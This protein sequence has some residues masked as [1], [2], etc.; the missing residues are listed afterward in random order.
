MKTRRVIIKPSKYDAD[1]FV[2][3]FR[4]G[5]MPNGTISHLASMTPDHVDGTACKVHTVDEYVRTEL[6]YLDLLGTSYDGR[7]LVALVGVQSHQFHRALDLAALAV[8]RGAQAII[9][10]PHPMTCDTAMLQN[11][12]ASFA[13]AEAELLWPAILSDTAAGELRP[14]YGLDRK[15]MSRLDPPILRPLPEQELRRYAVPMMGVYPARGCPY[16]CNFCSV[17]KIAGRR[18]RGQPI[19]TTTASLRAAKQAGVRYIMFTSDNFN[20]YPEAH[21]LLDIMIAE[22]IHLPFFAQCDALLHRQEDLVEKMARAG[23][24]QIFVGAESFDRYALK[25]TRKFH[26]NPEAYARIVAMCRARGITSH[27]SNIIGFP[28]DTAESVRGH[29][30]ALR[31]LDPDLASFYILTPIPGSD[32]YDDFRR[33]GIISE[34]NL[35][36]FD[37]TC[38]T[39]RHPHFSGKELL[40]LLF[41]SY[42]TFYSTRGTLSRLA[43]LMNGP[44]DYR[45]SAALVAVAGFSAMS[46]WAA[47]VGRHPMAG[48]IARIRRD[49]ARDYADLRRSVFGIDRAPLPDS[50]ALPD[51]DA[52]IGRGEEMPAV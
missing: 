26:N 34:N 14:V 23:S 19:E 27:F 12:G 3:R 42:G 5:F 45:R 9:G 20:K 52:G 39:W 50:L 43:R 37:A 10:G 7:T 2:E 21:A 51:A 33:R 31:K 49:H 18:I 17:V 25:N 15:W 44:R 29:L 46:R 24:H 11:R 1:G 22:R 38:A 36:R 41:R 30:A 16:D 48:G 4:R 32:Q 40:Q 13:L 47:S 8:R 28:S 35:D 6:S